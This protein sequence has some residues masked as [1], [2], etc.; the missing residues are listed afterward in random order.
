MFLGPSGKAIIFTF[1]SSISLK[2]IRAASSLAIS[3]FS[4]ASAAV[5]STALTGGVFFV[6]PA[7][8]LAGLGD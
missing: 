7:S 1:F 4:I 3:S 5:L 6:P 8:L 2:A